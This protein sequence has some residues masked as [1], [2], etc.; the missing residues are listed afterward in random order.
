MATEM[1]S[2]IFMYKVS[3][4]DLYIISVLQEMKFYLNLR[5]DL[6]WESSDM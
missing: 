3:E 2:K 6:V 4:S 5:Q 1:L